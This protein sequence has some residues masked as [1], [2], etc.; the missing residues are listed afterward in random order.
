MRF[1]FALWSPLWRKVRALEAQGKLEEAALLLAEAGEHKE[2]GRFLK[3]AGEREFVLEKRIDLWRRA[4]D[5]WQEKDAERQIIQRRLA[6]DLRRFGQQ[7]HRIS[8]VHREAL[9]QAAILFEEIKAWEEAESIY[10]ELGDLEGRA[11]CLKEAGA[12]DELEK[13]LDQINQESAKKE[14][15]EALLARFEEAIAH[16]ERLFAREI[17]EKAHKLLRQDK[18]LRDLE[19]RLLAKWPKKQ[20]ELGFQGKRLTLISGLPV[21][22]GRGEVEIV[23]RGASLSR[24]HAE[25]TH[26]EEGWLL[27]DCGSRN[28]IRIRGLPMG[29]H[30]ALPLG[31][32]IEVSLGQDVELRLCA[33]ESMLEIE[34][35]AGLDRGRLFWVGLAK[36]GKTLFELRDLPAKIRFEPKRVR[37]ESEKEMWLEHESGRKALRG[38]IDLL[39]GD[40]IFL[41]GERLEV[42]G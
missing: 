3:R 35:T 18:I 16:G 6:E 27:V 30:F 17:L 39:I 25:I 5:Q 10:R 24:R 41:A 4:L 26:E 11:R 22:I 42:L 28:G 8:Q 31:E 20:V 19:S 34:V 21:T 1:F 33:K 7:G 38:G 40:R 36:E 23:L 29:L 12:I 32:A 15:A 14:E 2:A 13:V 9:K 37:L